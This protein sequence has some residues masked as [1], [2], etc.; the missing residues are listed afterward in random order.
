MAKTVSTDQVVSV[1]G[2]ILKLTNLDKVMYPATGTTKGEVINYYAQIAES[3]I[4]HAAGRPATRKR[5]VHGVGTAQQ[6]GSVFFQKNLDNATP[7]WVARFGI[8]HSTRENLYPVIND[9]PTLIWL[10]QIASLEIHLP[11]W[12]F[13]P[14]G[15]RRN[16]DRLVLDLDPGDGVGLLECAEVARLCRPILEGMGL[17]AVPVT[18]GS[19]GI[20]LYAALPGAQ[21]AEEISAVAHQ[22][23]RMLEVDHPDLVVSDMKKSLRKSKVLLDWSQNNGNKTTIA[24][25]S[26]RGL[27]QPMVACPRTWE[28][29]EDPKLRQLDYLEVLERVRED[30]DSMASIDPPVAT[31][32]RLEL[33]RQ[34]RDASK[35]P[36]PVPTGTPATSGGR[37]FVI[38]EHHARRLHYDLR[39]ERDGVLASWAIPKGPPMTPE[40]NRL[41]VQTED[42]PMQ[43]A[44]FEG[45]IPAGEYGAGSMSIWDSG[46]YELEKWRDGKEIILT[47]HG[48][49]DGGL[50]QSRRYALI[51]T[52]GRDKK[53]AKNWL[54]HLMKD[55]QSA[56]QLPSPQGPA[57]E[58]PDIKPMLATAG[59]LGLVKTGDWAYEV[60]WDGFRCIATVSDGQV[61]LR[62]RSG[63]DM[64]A[65]FPEL[66]ELADVFSGHDVIVDGE[67]VAL[68]PSGR[69]SFG[70]LQTRAN[71]TKA[72]QVAAAR[73]QQSV[74]LMIFDLLHV[75]GDSLLRRP[76][77]E[78]R[79]I[80]EGLVGADGSKIHLPPALDTDAE[81]A[82][83]MSKSLKLEGIVAK[84]R[85]S[86]YQPAQR[87]HTWI[88]IKNQHSIE[89]IIIGWRPGK[90]NRASLVGSLLMAIPDGDQLRYIGRVGSG[91]TERD[92]R[93][94]TTKLG[95]DEQS[96][97]PAEGVP[98]ADAA[99]ARWV[100]PNYVGEVIYSETSAEGK[101]RHPVWKGW[102]IDKSP[103]DLHHD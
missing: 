90:G 12:R 67:I 15:E 61:R 51:Q 38:Q 1:G 19:K 6:P 98:D 18:S 49:A 10:A 81:G 11:Q 79:E 65:T 48:R 83:A 102:R 101:L 89:V 7:A 35:T 74:E 70:L 57:D 28:E 46:T 31:A 2:R 96:T 99:D 64:T 76:Y 33:Y 22:L 26:M 40:V 45:S 66:Q 86:V 54:I 16:P 77:A 100:H 68:D 80:L 23:A 69:P 5:W 44:T 17:S 72:D 47:L 42:H 8:E 52:G 20:H 59:T 55:Q 21:S 53:S 97:C 88:K 71:L 25:Y 29:L 75:D 39:L 78:R 9:L 4:K 94:L 103:E 27:L 43:Y 63:M 50:Q 85:S 41:A 82:L 24:P 92:I 3:F 32:D 60:K 13:G 93:E 91:F 84:G 30:G 34:M 36:E 62:S 56:T 73:K 95:A 37:T 14:G 87:A 58:L